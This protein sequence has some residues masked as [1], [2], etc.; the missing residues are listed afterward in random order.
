MDQI[1]TDFPFRL[2]LLYN[3]FKKSYT[4]ETVLCEM[5]LTVKMAYEFYLDSRHQPKDMLIIHTTHMFISRGVQV[6]NIHIHAI[7]IILCMC[8]RQS[9]SYRR[10]LITFALGG[11]R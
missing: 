8:R 11:G 3:T 5:A 10:D 1:N 7:Y 4:D 9:Q 6:Y 2:F